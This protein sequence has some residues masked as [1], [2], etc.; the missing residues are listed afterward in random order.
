[1]KRLQ[2]IECRWARLLGIRDGVIG[3]LE[4][5]LAAC[6]GVAEFERVGHPA[7]LW[8]VK[9]RRFIETTVEATK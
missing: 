4:E 2:D 5:W 9:A 8:K 1:V 6:E 7:W 3:L